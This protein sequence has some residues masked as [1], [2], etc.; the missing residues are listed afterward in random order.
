MR[1]SVM[2]I[3]PALLSLA[4]F[5]AQ[6][7]AVVMHHRNPGRTSK[8]ED[9]LGWL[10]RANRRQPGSNPPVFARLVPA[11]PRAD[12]N[13]YACFSR[14]RIRLHADVIDN[15]TDSSSLLSNLKC[16]TPPEPS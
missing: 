12:S 16:R 13:F 10:F 9:R 7:D 8:G 11:S 1:P 2:R 3:V 6:G 5:V 15:T 14:G 4:V